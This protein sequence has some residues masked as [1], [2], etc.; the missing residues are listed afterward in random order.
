LFSLIL[1]IAA[2]F[3][4]GLKGSAEIWVIFAA[5]QE[6]DKTLRISINTALT[7]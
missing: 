6:T 7:G 1:A 2:K 5:P 3:K 4:T